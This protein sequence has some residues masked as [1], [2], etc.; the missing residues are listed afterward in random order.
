MERGHRKGWRPSLAAVD[1]RSLVPVEDDVGGIVLYL[2]GEPA[3]YVLDGEWF[4]AVP[5][6]RPGAGVTVAPAHPVVDEHRV[7]PPPRGAM[8]PPGPP[9]TA[10]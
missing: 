9:T 4:P 6:P 8:R 3:Y 7:E 1:A 2:N 10:S 5:S